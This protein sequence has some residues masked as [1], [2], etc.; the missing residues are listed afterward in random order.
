MCILQYEVDKSKLEG[1]Q[2]KAM[3]YMYRSALTF[4]RLQQMTENDWV[5]MG[6]KVRE[7]KH[8]M[9]EEYSIS[10]VSRRQSAFR[11]MR[12][13]RKIKRKPTVNELADYE[14]KIDPMDDKSIDAMK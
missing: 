3:S 11:Y 13:D 10:T 8:A 6:D 14:A 7:S 4:T 2:K 12:E 1:V 9:L 5:T